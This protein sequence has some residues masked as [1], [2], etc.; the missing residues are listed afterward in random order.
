MQAQGTT[1]ALSRASARA[2]R[3]R[4]VARRPLVVRAATAVVTGGSRGIGECRRGAVGAWLGP[5]PPPLPPPPWPPLPAVAQEMRS[6][7]TPSHLRA[8]ALSPAGLALV[9]QLL[10]RGDTVIATARSGA[11]APALQQL[12]ASAGGR[13]HVTDLDASKPESIQRWA[14]EVQ[15]KAARVDVSAAPQR[16]EWPCG[17]QGGRAGRR[18]R[19][20]CAARRAVLWCAPLP[21]R[22]RRLCLQVRIGTPPPPASLLHAVQLLINNAGA[23]EQPKPFGQ[24]PASDLTDMFALNAAGA[25]ADAAHGLQRPACHACPHPSACQA[26]VPRACGC[27][28]RL[29]CRPTAALAAGWRARWH[30]SVAGL[31]APSGGLLPL[32][33]D[34]DGRPL[35]APPAARLPPGVQA[36]SW[37]LRSST[38]A[39]CWASRPPWQTSAAG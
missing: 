37:S 11:S 14:A 19:G 8:T 34:T 18:L 23:M 35:L 16:G 15:E 36:L 7:A 6:G 29:R 39:A 33:A 22:S 32:R 2:A 4:T 31:R 13:L 17:A 27:T 21:R 12:A 20:R 30:Q 5:P 26:A 9:K 10:Q 38:A 25:P 28:R 24:V 3:P 1:A